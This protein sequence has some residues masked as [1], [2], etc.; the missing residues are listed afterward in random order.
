MGGHYTHHAS[1]VSRVTCPGFERYF[2]PNSLTLQPCSV[3]ENEGGMATW[4]FRKA[5]VLGLTRS[6]YE[7]SKLPA[8][9][10]ALVTASVTWPWLKFT[11]SWKAHVPPPAVM[12]PSKE[13][14]PGKVAEH[15]KGAFGGCL[16]SSPT[17]QVDGG[18]DLGKACFIREYAAHNKKA[19]YCTIVALNRKRRNSEE[20]FTSVHER[21]TPCRRVTVCPKR[22]LYTPKSA[23]ESTL[24]AFYAVMHNV[25]D[26]WSY[27][28]EESRRSREPLAFELF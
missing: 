24:H 23:P 18:N 19:R 14:H 1:E 8:S 7:I 4:K 22:N 9:L 16:L 11:C 17:K 15:N 12:L 6:T 3:M 21:R 2:P 28:S 25:S 20:P 27:L 13:S 10:S 5:S 26:E